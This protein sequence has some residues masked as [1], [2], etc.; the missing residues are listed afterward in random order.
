M[1][2]SWETCKSEKKSVFVYGQN[3][4][5]YKILLWDNWK[6]LGLLKAL[7]IKKV[8]SLTVPLW[9]CKCGELFG[10]E[11]CAQDASSRDSKSS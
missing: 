7:Y 9:L 4:I 10:M 5:V 1:R 3:W 11:Q 6:A 2:K 8:I